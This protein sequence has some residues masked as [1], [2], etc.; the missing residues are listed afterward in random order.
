MQL[1]EAEDGVQLFRR[2]LARFPE[3]RAI[4]S[5]G[6]AVPE[7]GVPSAPAGLGWLPKP[8]TA[9]SLASA[10]SDALEGR[11]P[12]AFSLGGRLLNDDA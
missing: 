8:Y 10:V 9:D 11:P 7:A 4:L 2:I 3:Q 6:H 1:N 5:S 12:R